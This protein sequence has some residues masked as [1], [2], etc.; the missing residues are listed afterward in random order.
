MPGEKL[1]NNSVF[2]SVFKRVCIH[3]NIILNFQKY[4]QINVYDLT[5]L[6][7]SMMLSN[8]REMVSFDLEAVLRDFTENCAARFEL[9]SDYLHIQY[10]MAE[11]SIKLKEIASTSTSQL[12]LPDSK[13][14]LTVYLF[15]RN[16]EQSFQLSVSASFACRDVLSMAKSEFNL[17][18]SKYWSLFEVFDNEQHKMLNE[19]SSNPLNNLI[20]LERILPVSAKLIDSLSKWNSFSLV[21][22]SNFIQIDL[23]KYFLTGNQVYKILIS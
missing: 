10:K 23:E 7:S 14:L 6:F 17:C 8:S 9:K 19:S 20:L 22:K 15:H 13:F 12:I 18:D 1:G 11:K 4:N 21:V 5:T 2:L 3:L 16:S